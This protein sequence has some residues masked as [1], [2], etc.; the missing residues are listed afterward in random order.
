MQESPL[1]CF[2]GIFIVGFAE[3]A[4]VFARVRLQFLGTLIAAAFRLGQYHQIPG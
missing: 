2:C 1:S 3:V 4:E